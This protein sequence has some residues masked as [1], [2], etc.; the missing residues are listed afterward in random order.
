MMASSGKEK[1]IDIIL[2]I[3]LFALLAVPLAA[4]GWHHS[5]LSLFQPKDSILLSLKRFYP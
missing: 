2:A 1:I 5:K 3:L 4:L